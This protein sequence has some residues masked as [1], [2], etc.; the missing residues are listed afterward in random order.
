MS[1]LLRDK[2]YKSGERRKSGTER[3]TVK[4]T[5]TGLALWLQKI[6]CVIVTVQIGCVVVGVF[7]YSKLRV[8]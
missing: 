4:E 6:S 1:G 2:L 3:Q 5:S 8:L 7:K